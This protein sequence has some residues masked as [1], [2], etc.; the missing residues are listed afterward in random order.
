MKQFL[1]E[2]PHFTQSFFLET[3]GFNRPRDGKLYTDAL[4]EA[5]M[6]ED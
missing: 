2:N 6:P 1:A 4:A 3:H 5:G